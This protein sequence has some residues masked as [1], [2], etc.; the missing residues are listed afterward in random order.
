MYGQGLFLRTTNIAIVTAR[1]PVDPLYDEILKLFYG[2]YFYNETEDPNH[3]LI[4]KYNDLKYIKKIRFAALELLLRMM[5]PIRDA[6]VI[7]QDKN[8]P[9]Y[10]YNEVQKASL[11][12]SQGKTPREIGNKGARLNTLNPLECAILAGDQSLALNFL[13]LGIITDNLENFSVNLA[14]IY[15]NLKN[16]DCK[17]DLQ[18]M[19]N[20]LNAVLSEPVLNINL[21]ETKNCCDS[22]ARF[23]YML[24]LHVTLI[25]LGIGI[26]VMSLC[27]LDKENPSYSIL[28]TLGSAAIGGGFTGIFSS[29]SQQSREETVNRNALHKSSFTQLWQDVLASTISLSGQITD[30]GLAYIATHTVIARMPSQVKEIPNKQMIFSTLDKAGLSNPERSNPS[31]LE[32]HEKKIDSI[33][34][35]PLLS[36][37]MV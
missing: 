9:F 8:L 23:K 35:N 28:M 11:S 4:D 34:R 1:A 17:D 25:S 19:C 16:S 6:V 20:A 26:I 7:S 33:V 36:M 31:N 30:I 37:S 2:D 10:I 29:V 32:S 5:A 18:K 12:L 21:R 15:G 3:D 13:N 24:I 22:V 14:T 27:I